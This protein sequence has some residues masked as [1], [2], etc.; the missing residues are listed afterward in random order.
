[1]STSVYSHCAEAN[2]RC[3]AP[4]P[5]TEGP[6]ST[7]SH[8]QSPTCKK[9][10][11][12]QASPKVTAAH[13]ANVQVAP[14]HAETLPSSQNKGAIVVVGK[15]AKVKEVGGTERKVNPAQQEHRASRLAHPG[16]IQVHLC[17]AS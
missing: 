9:R 6:S 12:G 8:V 11:P 15:L 13:A 17:L 7:K 4:A 3:F 14:Q 2:R 5:V 16:L 10:I 1:M